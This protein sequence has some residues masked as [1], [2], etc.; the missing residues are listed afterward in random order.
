MA[1]DSKPILPLDLLPTIADSQVQFTVATFYLLN[2]T[3]KRIFEAKL[4]NLVKLTSSSAIGSFLAH[5]R[6][7]TSN[8]QLH[9]LSL[10]RHLEIELEDH[11]LEHDLY[12]ETLGQAF[13]VWRNDDR[14]PNGIFSNLKTLHI[15]TRTDDWPVLSIHIGAAPTLPVLARRVLHIAQAKHL[16]WQHHHCPSDPDGE[17]PTPDTGQL[18]S[19]PYRNHFAVDAAR[20][21]P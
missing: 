4:Y 17:G 21:S 15:V 10:I 20:D 6:S 16:R 12:R 13:G 7:P 14:F 1:D 18:I 8:R 5:F 11:F 2:K 3:T 19:K 9:L